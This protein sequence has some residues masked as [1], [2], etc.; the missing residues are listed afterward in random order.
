MPLA[1]FEIWRFCGRRIVAVA[2]LLFAALLAAG[3]VDQWRGEELAHDGGFFGYA[4]L[5]AAVLLM[6]FGFAADRRLRFDEYL[7]VNHVSAPSYYTAKVLAMAGVLVGFGVIAAVLEAAFAGGNLADAFWL[8]AAFTL[9]AWI[10]APFAMFVE[11][12]LDTS[13][14]AAAVLLGFFALVLAEYLSL[15]RLV[16]VELLGLQGLIVGDWRSLGPLAIRA[17]LFAPVA[18]A[19]TGALDAVRLRRC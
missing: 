16:S 10:F 1:S 13:V 9:V 14:P 11:M 2:L 18:F 3:R 8:A 5:L 6:R 15:R 7:V 19:A 12:R 17:V 4:Y